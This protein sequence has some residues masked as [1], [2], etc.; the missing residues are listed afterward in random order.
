MYC[1]SGPI[2]LPSAIPEMD[3]EVEHV[4][5]MTMLT[6]QVNVNEPSTRVTLSVEETTAPLRSVHWYVVLGYTP[7]LHV[8]TSPAVNG[9][10][11]GL[12][13]TGITTGQPVFTLQTSAISNT[14]RVTVLCW[15]TLTGSL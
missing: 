15:L 9:P 8:N 5:G 4:A 2:Y 6:V 7:E 11:D 14:V 10:V 12:I 13:I 1:K 3:L